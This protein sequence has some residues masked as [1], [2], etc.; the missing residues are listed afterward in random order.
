MNFIPRWLIIIIILALYARLYR[1]IYNA[2]SR[3][4]SFDDGSSPNALESHISPETGSVASTHRI[5]RPSDTLNIT[6][7][8]TIPDIE[9]NNSTG[10]GR[11]HTR[12]PS[13][14]L[15]RLA[16]QMMM[17]PL[18]YMLIWAIPTTIRI[19][20]SVSGRA[21]PFGI[22]TVD[23]ASAVVVL[24]SGHMVNVFLRRVSLSKDSLMPSFTESMKLHLVLGAIGSHSYPRLS[25][26]RRSWQST[27]NTRSKL[28]E[29]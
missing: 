9:Q 27:L 11:T 4:V 13:P 16:R 5:G 22:A 25:L 6:S 12:L 3:F 26:R 23:K 2:H 21:A 8:D 18:V 19:Y 29:L 24:Y 17:Y 14:V 7:K 10:N 15:K 20:Q 1:I 28:R